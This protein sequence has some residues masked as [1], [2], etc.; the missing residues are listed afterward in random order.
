MVF[1]SHA[2][3]EVAYLADQVLIIQGGRVVQTMS[4]E[5]FADDLRN[6]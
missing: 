4:K 6:L 5:D 2:R 3:E 1:V